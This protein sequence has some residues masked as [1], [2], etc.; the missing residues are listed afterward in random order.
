MTDYVESAGD[1]YLEQTF[2]ASDFVC[3]VGYGEH[4]TS[5]LN[6]KE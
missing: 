1:K 2:V 6:A 5:R 4:D 3:G